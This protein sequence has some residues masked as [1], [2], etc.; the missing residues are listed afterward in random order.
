MSTRQRPSPDCHSFTLFPTAVRGQTSK[1]WVTF[2]PPSHLHIQKK[3]VHLCLHVEIEFTSFKLYYPWSVN[4][5]LYNLLPGRLPWN[6][7][8]T[9]WLCMGMPGHRRKTPKQGNDTERNEQHRGSGI[10]QGQRKRE[11]GKMRQQHENG[12]AGKRESAKVARTME[13]SGN[14]KHIDPVKT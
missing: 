1:R 10:K 3:C 2:L 12:R 8:A 13:N 4:P 14:H 7:H 11:T 6:K 9:F 5:N